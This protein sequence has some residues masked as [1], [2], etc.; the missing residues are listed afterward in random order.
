M[1]GNQ[2][3]AH[4]MR[5]HVPIWVCSEHIKLCQR[6]KELGELLRTPATA[7][8]V[9]E[10]VIGISDACDLHDVGLEPGQIVASDILGDEIEL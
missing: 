6:N 7:R 5:T 2:H 8:F 9:L 3:R 1:K 10:G 4:G